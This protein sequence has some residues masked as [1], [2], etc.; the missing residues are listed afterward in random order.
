M[1][2]ILNISLD[3]IFFDEMTSGQIQ[4]NQAGRKHT[5]R[6]QGATRQCVC[7]CPIFSL[8]IETVSF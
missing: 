4:Q 3:E 7:F 1:L 2:H 6:S 8:S 5:P